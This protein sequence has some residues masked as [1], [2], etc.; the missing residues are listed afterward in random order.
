MTARAPF[1]LYLI[2]IYSTY[3]FDT[4]FEPLRNVALN[5]VLCLLFSVFRAFCVCT[6]LCLLYTVPC[7]R[8]TQCRARCTH[9]GLCLWHTRSSVPL[10]DALSV[11]VVLCPV[12][13]VQCSLHVIDTLLRTR[14]TLFFIQCTPFRACAD[15]SVPVIHSSVHNAPCSVLVGHF[16][17]PDMLCSEPDVL[18]SVPDMLCSVTVGHCSM[19]DMLCSVPVGHGSMS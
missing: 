1:C 9:T 14:Y 11:P 4:L 16:S 10:A 5:N 17:V 7:A 12:H 15:C 18:L 2:P 6:V 13:G 19:P 8:Y 3:I